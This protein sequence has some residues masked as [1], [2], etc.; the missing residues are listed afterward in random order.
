M[1]ADP[2]NSPESRSASAQP[3]NTSEAA[4]ADLEMP[5]LTLRGLMSHFG[6]GVILMMTGI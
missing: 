2:S 6:P 1:S 4:F 5:D 3:S